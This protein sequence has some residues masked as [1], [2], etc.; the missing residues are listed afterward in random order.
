MEKVGT[1]DK[2]V[3][4]VTVFKNNIFG[5]RIKNFGEACEG[6]GR[7]ILEAERNSV[8]GY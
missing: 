2:S 1:A 6:F 7:K 4:M 3:S 8:E 5:L